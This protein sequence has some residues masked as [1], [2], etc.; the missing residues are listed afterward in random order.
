MLKNFTPL[1]YFLLAKVFIN[2]IIFVIFAKTEHNFSK[3]SHNL[4]IYFI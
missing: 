4:L 1:I 2:P 3:M